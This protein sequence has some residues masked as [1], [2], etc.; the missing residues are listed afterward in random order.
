MPKKSLTLKLFDPGMTH[1]HRVGLAGLYMTLQ[2]LDPA[3]YAEAGGW[4]LNPQSVKLHWTRTPR[5][6][7]EPIIKKSFGISPEGI[8]Q[9]DAHKSSSM[10]DLNRLLL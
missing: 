10:G 4:E 8:I 6:L 3:K 2:R 9:F 1:L 7:L 5:D